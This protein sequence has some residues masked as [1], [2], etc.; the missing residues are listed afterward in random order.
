MRSKITCS[1]IFQYVYT[2]HIMY[3]SLFSTFYLKYI[4][5]CNVIIV[6]IFQLLY[7]I[8]F[9]IYHKLTFETKPYLIVRKPR[10][11][12]FRS[13]MQNLLWFQHMYWFTI[14]FIKSFCWPSCLTKESL[15]FQKCEVVWLLKYVSVCVCACVFT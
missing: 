2:K 3:T 12:W 4:L 1:N 9:C 8:L 7:S 11:I 13:N 10:S 5:H 6:S 15:S 14:F